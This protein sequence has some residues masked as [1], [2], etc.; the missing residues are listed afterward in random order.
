M[1]VVIEKGFDHASILVYSSLV[2]I[3]SKMVPLV[4]KNLNWKEKFSLFADLLKNDFPCPK[5]LEAEL[6]LWETFG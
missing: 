3:L 1:T 5:A 2:I 4:Y 6:D